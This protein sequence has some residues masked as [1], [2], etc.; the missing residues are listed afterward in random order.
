MAR[1]IAED[2]DVVI[3]LGLL[4]DRFFFGLG[5]VYRVGVAV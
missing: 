1:A 4:F 2:L 3:E 5:D